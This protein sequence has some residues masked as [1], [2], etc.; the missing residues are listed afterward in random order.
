MADKQDVRE[1]QMTIANNVDYLRG[2][3]GKDSVL[4]SIIN[5]LLISF[6]KGYIQ[7]NTNCND[8]I[9]TGCYSLNWS[10]N[11]GNINFPN[12]NYCFGALLVFASNGNAIIQVVHCIDYLY[13][14][15]RYDGIWKPWKSIT[16]T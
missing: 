13:I 4:I 9:N 2:L 8:L 5:T 12:N 16:L 3:N 1:D 14:R 6:G 10:S 15:I 7:K 11:M